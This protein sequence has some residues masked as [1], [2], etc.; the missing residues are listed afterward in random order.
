MAFL[1]LVRKR[2]RGAAAASTAAAAAAAA[3][4]SAAAGPAAA[5][6]SP[7]GRRGG[8][9]AASVGRS[10]GRSGAP[11]QPLSAEDRLLQ[12][13]AEHAAELFAEATGGGE[14]PLEGEQAA[15]PVPQPQAPLPAG[16]GAATAAA[17]A[18]AHGA[19]GVLRRP[20]KSELVVRVAPLTVRAA[21]SNVRLWAAFMADGRL[22][23]EVG[24]GPELF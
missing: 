24:G 13:A 16:M 21:F 5:G 15:A 1:Y 20:H 4:A 18:H 3:V 7:D 11:N 6:A 12:L 22:A 19:F 2:R 23:Q 14:G 9:D 8:A 10:S 17:A